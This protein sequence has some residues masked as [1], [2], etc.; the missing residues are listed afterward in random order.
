MAAVTSAITGG[1]GLSRNKRY[2]RKKS[3]VKTSLTI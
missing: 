2:G 3:K 1:L